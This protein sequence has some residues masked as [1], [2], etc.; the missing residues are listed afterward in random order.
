MKETVTKKIVPLI[1]A[2]CIVAG[3]LMIFL[4]ESDKAKTENTERSGEL[5]TYSEMLEKKLEDVLSAIRGMEYAKVMI[6]FESSFEKI[7][8]NN[9]RYE[10]NAGISDISTGKTTEKEIVLAG[11]G[12][13]GKQPILLKELCP[14]V[15][16]VAVIYG[17]NIDKETE[18]KV[19]NAVAVLFGISEFRVSLIN[20][21]GN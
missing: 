2:V 11:A 15:K 12:A 9:A 10:E 18:E 16:G 19:K 1:F 6:T 13:E 3:I 17:G 4:S 14:R 7:Y 8:A 21:N 5:E 20:G